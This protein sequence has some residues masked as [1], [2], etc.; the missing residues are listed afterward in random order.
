[1]KQID[2]A[3]EHKPAIPAISIRHITTFNQLSSDIKMDLFIKH[4]NLSDT[5]DLK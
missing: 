1:L 2:K 4:N 3:S 5:V